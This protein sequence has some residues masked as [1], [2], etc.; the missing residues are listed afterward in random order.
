M[1]KLSKAV[2]HSEELYS[3]TDS[4][5]TDARSK[6]ETSAYRDWLI[7][8]LSLEKLEWSQAMH[9][10]SACKAV[11]EQLSAVVSPGQQVLSLA[12]L[13]NFVLRILCRAFTRI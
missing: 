11:Y 7:G 12:I 6:L 2:K 5:K 10:F 4:S 8:T 9:S 3:L 13:E 1:R